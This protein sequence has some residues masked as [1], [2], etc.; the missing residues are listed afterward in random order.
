MK[1][2]IDSSSQQQ[3]NN[4]NSTQTFTNFSDSQNEQNLNNFIE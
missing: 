4:E 1:Y 2:E 3:N